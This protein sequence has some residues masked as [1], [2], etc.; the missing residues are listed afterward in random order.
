MSSHSEQ[1]TR[2]HKKRSRTRLLL[3]EAA[4]QTIAELGEG[5]TVAD[6]VERAGVSHGTFYN[7]FDDRQQ[8]LEA[9]TA[10]LVE[11]F[12]AT[13]AVTIDEPDPALRF[14]TISARAL[15]MAAASPT[16]AAVVVHL[17]AAQRALVVDGP[18]SYLVHDLR[19]GHA[20][21]R[22]IDPPD[23]AT[24]DVILGA[25]LLATRRLIDGDVS[26]HYCRD[27]IRRLLLSLGVAPADA[28]NLANHAC[29]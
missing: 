2:G 18:L 19:D 27:V 7:Y 3:L 20:H 26:E 9:L 23:T 24:L 21:G 12:A 15:R 25:L 5:F 11:V 17:E 13:A 4:Q 1:L 8:L 29:A 28:T 10:H 16:L 14:A 6:V 22:F